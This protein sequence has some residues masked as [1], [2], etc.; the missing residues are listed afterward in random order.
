MSAFFPNGPPV[1]VPGIDI[2]Q[3][4]APKAGMLE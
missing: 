3:P 4:R 2:V 1:G